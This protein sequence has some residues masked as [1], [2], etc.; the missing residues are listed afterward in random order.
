MTD[1]TTLTHDLINAWIDK[2][3]EGP[4]AL[5]CR[6]KLIPVEGEDGV[7]FPPT[8]A[9]E[10]KDDKSSYCIDTLADG[11]KTV[12]VDSVGSQA[13]RMEPLF[14]RAKP[15]RP[16][17]PLAK[18][19]PQVEIT[20]GEGHPN[21]V[22][23]LEAGHRLGD[24]IVRASDLAADAQAAF[25]ALNDRGDAGPIAR[26]A[27]TSLVFGAWD[28][29]D[30]HTRL[31]RIVQS[32]IRA[33]DIS[34]LKRSA[35]YVPPVDYAALQVFSEDEK[36][37]A[38]GNA[39]SP[40]A[41]RGFVH[42]PS[43]DAPGGVVARGGIFRDVTI[44]LTTLRQLDAR[45]KG[46]E[47]RRYILGLALVA[48]AEPM[49]GFLRQGCLL[50]G[51]FH[52]R[53]EG[54]GG[55][56]PPAPFRLFQALVAGAYGGRWAAEPAE[57]KDAAFRWLA[58][59]APPVIAAPAGR[60]GRAVM[61]YVPNNDLD[62]MGGDLR[63]VSKIRTPKTVRPLLLPQGV[64][65]LYVWRFDAGEEAQAERIA[66]LAHRLHTL[67][68]GVNA[69]SARGAVMA[70][71]EAE[72]L[73]DGHPGSRHHPF[74]DGG[75]QGDPWCPLPGS[76]DSLKARHRDLGG[77]Y[78]LHVEKGRRHT[79]FQRAGKPD[80]VP[81][82]YDA[83]ASRFLFDLRDGSEES[84]GAFA[85][86][87]LAEA[88]RLAKALIEGAVAR[89]P[90]GEPQLLGR[91]DAGEADKPGRVRVIPLPSI[92]ATHTDPSIRR[93]L[94][95]VPPGCPLDRRDVAWAFT[96]LILP[97]GAVL[98]P[99]ADR[100]MLRHYAATPKRTAALW[101]SVTPVALPVARPGGKV[102]GGARV[103]SEAGAVHA[104]RQ[105]LRHIGIRG[106]GR[107]QVR[108]RR[109]PWH[110]KGERAEAF[111]WDRFSKDR[112]WH[113]EVR[114]PEPVAGPLVIGCGR[115]RGLGLMAPEWEHESP[116]D[117][118][119]FTLAP[120]SRPP[121]EQR[122]KVTEAARRALMSLDGGV[123][124]GLVSPLFSGHLGAD[125]GPARP[126][127]HGHAFLVAEDADGDGLLDRLRVLAP[128]AADRSFRPGDGDVLCFAAVVER[129]SQVRAGPAGVL[130]LIRTDPGEPPGAAVWAT[131]WNS[132]TAYRPTRHPRRSQ[133][134]AAAFAADVQAEC[135]RR[136]LPI[137]RSVEVSSIRAQDGGGLCADLRLTFAAAVRGPILL[138]RDSHQGGGW[139]VPDP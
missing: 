40:L 121:V 76:L 74:P 53:R 30:T 26:L 91:R 2:P 61:L 50:T 15:G 102:G 109:E 120:G 118:V 108:V 128:W 1:A 129:L 125:P 127:Y 44:N 99:A 115:F 126:G 62:A 31:P 41:Q 32:V 89:L 124:R 36:A 57:D 4:V 54:A 42:V 81:V 65:V 64:P 73:L 122:A 8:F 97:E 104:V 110:A 100:G 75:G 66:E 33:W 3:H 43:I 37:K 84:K 113:V 6:E 132:V 47:L 92:G 114:L 63:K 70:A 80:C 98:T 111:A 58:G 13:N 82:A 137:P 48:A 77:Q 105:A 10:K 35:Q 28:S 117:E 38:E 106:W 18:L 20:V 79:H 119:V 14:R 136:G 138:G 25:R 95:E 68:W 46:V 96:G 69:A 94:V 23:I 39:K 85:P 7:F 60:E 112:L 87:P 93:V 49:D 71:A 72:A 12:L 45:E 107:A 90:H 86:W 22:S 29:R 139:F 116:P 134:T 88:G 123:S 131:V 24:A 83:Q 67:G 130:D 101:R 5:H 21:P 19:V 17:N 78:R 52:G 9:A 55:D 51:R 56:W 133:D 34:E 103:A 135:A 27:P 16:D 59:L 11:T